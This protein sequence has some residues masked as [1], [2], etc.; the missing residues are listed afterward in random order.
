MPGPPRKSISAPSSGI[1]SAGMGRPL[2]ALATA[3]AIVSSPL[4]EAVKR[5]IT[6]RPPFGRWPAAGMAPISARLASPPRMLVVPP[7]PISLVARIVPGA[8]ATAS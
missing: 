3:P 7:G 4:T 5:R 6:P 1:A 8:R 2:T